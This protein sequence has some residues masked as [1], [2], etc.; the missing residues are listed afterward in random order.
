MCL[1][2]LVSSLLLSEID[3]KVF[4]NFFLSVGS[5]SVSFLCIF[6]GKA[7][8]AQLWTDLYVHTVKSS[9]IKT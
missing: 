4:G 8:R 7:V 9:F 5:Q 2:N 1:A 6:L 3:L